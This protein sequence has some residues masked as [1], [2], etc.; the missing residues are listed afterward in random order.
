VWLI[1][2]G[3]GWGKTRTAAE[4]VRDEVESGRK[5]RIALVASTIADCRDVMVEG[6]AGILACYPESQQPLYEPSLRKITFRNGAIAKTYSAEKPRQLRGPEHDGA[7]AD[8]LAQWD[9]LTETWDNLSFGLRIGPRPQVVVTTTPRPLKLLIDL[10]KAPGTVLTRG[11][12]RDNLCNLAPDFVREIFGKYGGTRIGRQELDG[13]LLEDVEGALWQ[14]SQIEN[15]RVVE[16]PPLKRI[17]VAIDPAVTSGEDSDET[18]IIVAGVSAA[19]HAYILAD[20]SCRESPDGWCG[21]AVKAYY[22]WE[23]D[24]IVGEVNNGGDLVETVLRTVD[25]NVPY[26][27]VHASR[28]KR[29]RA[30]PVA[31]LYEQCVAAGTLI[32]TEAGPVPIER[33]RVG[34]RVWTR[35]G[36]RRVEWAGRTG[37]KETVEI[38]A[39]GRRLVCTPDHPIFTQRGFIRA[40]QLVPKYDILCAWKPTPAATAEFRSQGS[41]GDVARAEPSIVGRRESPCAHL[42]NS[43]GCAITSREMATTE[44]VGTAGTNFCTAPSGARPMARFLKGGTYTTATEIRETTNWR[45]WRASRRA[46]TAASARR[47]LPIPAKS[48]RGCPKEKNSGGPTANRFR[49]FAT[50]ADR[51]LRARRLGC[52]SAPRPATLAIGLGAAAKPAPTQPVYNLTIEDQPEFFANGLLV[53]N[54]RV[55]HAGTFPDLEDQM[56][57]FVAGDSGSKSPDRVDALVW[58][59]TE[60][61][62]GSRRTTIRSYSGG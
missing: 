59:I 8:E 20:G 51:H 40:G 13:E 6:P 34:D 3:R 22:T 21:K 44:R 43:E 56:C 60:L 18:G 47:T 48:E 38:D 42:W 11:S 50:S 12:T 54:C 5:R 30:E 17:V 62:L 1:Q 53:H 28:G 10:C 52:V 9:P 29:A 58:A 57:A 39:G 45:T 14:R 4:W 16:V 33:V 25:R 36:L 32:E 15:S 24:R 46:S 2:T 31:A 37:I 55:H 61:A 7:W 19:E 35:V 27:A 49:G 26:K 23:A 41:I